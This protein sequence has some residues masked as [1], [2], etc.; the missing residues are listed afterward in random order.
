MHAYTKCGL[1]RG[2]ASS[3]M[4]PLACG[5]GRVIS[6]FGFSTALLL[7]VVIAAESGQAR[8]DEVSQ[9]SLDFSSAMDLAVAAQ[10][11][12]EAQRSTVSGSRESAVAAAQLPDPLLLAGLNDLTV[13]GPDQFTLR[14]ETD[15]QFVFALKQSFPGG[16]KRELRGARATAQAELQDTELQNQIRMVRRETGLAWLDVWKAVQAQELVQSSSVEAQ[17]QLE[18]VEINYHAG[19]AMQA[20]VL[21]ARVALE[22]L[23]DQR[24]GLQQQEWHGRNQLRRWIGVDA[25]RPVHTGLPEWQDPDMAEILDHLEHHPH[26]SA[27]A[28]AVDVASADLKLAHEDYK[29]D[30]SVQVGYGYRPEYSDYA[31][32]Q[33]ETALP[34]FTRN[35]QD[36]STQARAAEVTR[37]EL[38]W[39]DVLR[40]HRA[41]V[42]LNVTDWQRLQKRLAHF[43]ELILPQ[44]QQRLDSAL[45]AYGAGSG[46]LLGVLDARRSLLE[47]SMQRLD[48]EIDGARHQVELQYFSDVTPEESQS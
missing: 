38:L 3:F 33:F 21:A 47:I 24:A 15:T 44:A 32:V 7:T 28:R 35:R 11:L 36:R 4:A 1:F 23:Q 26:V 5:S 14:R 13:T 20:D 6:H 8:A 17:R 25:D 27:Q 22:L 34:F 2:C 9:S 19:R 39:E 37:A 30:W 48:L 10:P 46:S 16:N 42:Q 29:P 43:D 45:A 31:L 12:L 40:Q 18:A 41:T